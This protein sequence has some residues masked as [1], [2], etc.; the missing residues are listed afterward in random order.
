MPF[1]SLGDLP[2]PGIKPR[3]PLLQADSLLSEPPGKTM[4]AGVSSLSL[5]QGIFPTQGLNQGLLHCRQ[6]LCHLSSQGSPPASTGPLSGSFLAS[7]SQSCS[8]F[9]SLQE[10]GS[11]SPQSFTEL[12]GPKALNLYSISIIGRL[13][14][15]HAC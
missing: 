14:V 12:Q 11:Q 8:G 3:S 6:L 4:N 15:I 1:P 13:L 5:L 9:P 10:K 7:S 2:N